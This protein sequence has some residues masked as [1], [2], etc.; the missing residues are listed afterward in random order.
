MK[1]FLD[2]GNVNEIRQA[3]Q[4]AILDGVTTNPSLIARENKPFKETIL[5]I[6]S[7]VDGPVSV[8][9]TDLEK[10]AMLRQGR[11][12]ASWHK[13]VVV[14]L[15][16]TR[17]GVQACKALSGEGIK[18][19]MTLCFSAPQALL[20]A[21]AGAAYV[22]PFVGR[23]DDISANGLDL[24]RQVVQIFKNYNFA[25]QVLAASLRHP[26]HVV[27][28]ALA[29]AHVATMPWKVLNSLFEHPLT[30]KGLAQFAKDW[31]KT[32]QA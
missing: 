24:A 13:N 8:E 28:C 20:V 19:N 29:G 4:L 2:T 23:L 3:A 7:I 5:E 1:F 11:E 30:D 6:C 32:K 9:V 17:E 16:I 22:S 25:T 27:E 18:I 21:K 14:K 15:P 10:E 12:Y 26:M 31:E